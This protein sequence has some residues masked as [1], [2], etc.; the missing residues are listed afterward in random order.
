MI[1]IDF[2]RTNVP[3]PCQ[4]LCYSKT[5]FAFVGTNPQLIYYFQVLSLGT[6]LPA[7]YKFNSGQRIHKWTILHYSPFKVVIYFQ[8]KQLLTSEITLR[9]MPHIRGYEMIL[10]QTK[11]AFFAIV[12]SYKTSQ[13]G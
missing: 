2:T 3:A 11:F 5:E 8:S 13:S 6:P 10:H 1:E 7:D 9:I 4:F 12:Y